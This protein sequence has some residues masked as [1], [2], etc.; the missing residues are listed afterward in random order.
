VDNE[1]EDG[2][3]AL[4]AHVHVGTRNALQYSMSRNCSRIQKNS[5]LG[6]ILDSVQLLDQYA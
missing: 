4:H 3:F 5:F 2:Q 1:F 6:S